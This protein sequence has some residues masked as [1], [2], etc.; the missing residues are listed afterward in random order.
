[1]KNIWILAAALSLAVC[2]PGERRAAA[3]ADDHG[4]EEAGHDHIHVDV[5]LEKQK[6]WGIEIGAAVETVI[7]ISV[8][9]TGTV[10]LDLNRTA[11]VSS[12]AAGAIV[13]VATD[14]GRDVR[15]GQT[16]AVVNSPEF[17]RDRSD[18]LRARA[19]FN[20]ARLEV[21]R[22][23]LL[24]ADKAIEQ[25][26]FLRREAEFEDA[27]TEFGVLGSKLHSYGLEHKDIEAWLKECDDLDRDDWLCELVDPHLAVTS[28]VAGR[29]IFRDA[30]VGERIGPEKVLFTVSD[31]RM[32]WVLL[33]AYETDL[34]HLRPGAR[35]AVRSANFPDREFP[36]V[37]RIVADVIDE[38]LRTAKVRAE[39]VNSEGLLRPNMYIQGEIAVEGGERV[40]AVPSEAVQNLDGEKV[41]FAAESDVTF[42]VRHVEVGESGGGWTEIRKGLRPGSRVAVRGAFALKTEAAKASF[43]ELG[44][45]H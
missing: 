21:E 27:A 20:L 43:A 32:L 11:Q 3:P 41:V 36:G 39:V 6:E 2:G 45:V 24:V 15:R 37:V 26:E 16:L 44:H 23:R 34:R 12:L 25:R 17:A 4:P 22:A 9:M 31:L 29:V 14:L 35:V 10:G 7:P 40:T 28:P 1:M 5:P 18:F 33:D 38:K 19:R 30:V 42:A 13:S 8:R